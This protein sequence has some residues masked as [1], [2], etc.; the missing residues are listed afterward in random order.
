[1]RKSLQG[2]FITGTNTGVGKT[3]VT[4]QIAR[5]LTREGV[6]VGI[7]KPVCSG[8]GASTWDDV[9]RLSEA[10]DHRFPDDWI[11][12]QRFQAALAPPAAAKMEGRTVDR[13]LLRAGIFQWTDA[14]D[15]VLVEG[16]GGWRSPIADGET[17]ADLAVDFGLPV[18]LVAGLELGGVNHA[19]L[20]LESIER[21][22]LPVAG[23]V[24]NHH[25]PDVTVDVVALD[26]RSD[27]LQPVKG[28]AE[29]G[30]YEPSGVAAATAD[31]IRAHATAPVL[32][33]VFHRPDSGL[34]PDPSL[35]SVDWK[36]LCGPIWRECRN[37]NDE[38][39][40]KS[41]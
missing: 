22:G 30:H 21:R 14:A 4:V 29:A 5:Q 16:V 18:V 13:G 33:T 27:R 17:V 39:M 15:V 36:A 37:P 41:E 26:V 1:M 40:S 19:L 2:L 25:R 10:L 8:I 3:H 34:T 20:T 11:C 7:Y 28:P 23:I 38:R 6:R 32:A 9:V 31:G 35:G 12:P 24:L